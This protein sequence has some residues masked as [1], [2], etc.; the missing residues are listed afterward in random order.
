[1]V[2]G[3]LPGRDKIHASSLGGPVT[4]TPSSLEV[5]GQP[6][7]SNLVYQYGC[8]TGLEKINWSFDHSVL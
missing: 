4:D 6:S 7:S 1:V 8:M 5:N 2:T 3:I